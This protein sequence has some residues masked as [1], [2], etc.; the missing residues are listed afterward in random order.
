MNDNVFD[1]LQLCYKSQ[2]CHLLGGR[3]E[4]NQYLYIQHGNSGKGSLNFNEH[5]VDVY[6]RVTNRAMIYKSVVMLSC[7][8][9]LDILQED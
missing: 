4:L 7:H 5:M 1:S 6:A 3:R 8:R 9:C 2:V